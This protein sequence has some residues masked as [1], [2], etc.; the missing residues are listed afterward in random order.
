MHCASKSTLLWTKRLQLQID[1][2]SLSTGGKN[3]YL[4]ELRNKVVEKYKTKDYIC[5]QKEGNR[6]AAI[7]QLNLLECFENKSLLDQDYNTRDKGF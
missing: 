4:L 3:N 5:T 1:T 7:M 2:L 6:M